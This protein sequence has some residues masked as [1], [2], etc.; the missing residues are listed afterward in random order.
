MMKQ[1]YGAALVLMA[2]AAGVAGEAAAQDSEIVGTA[3][4]PGVI[5]AFITAGAIDPNGKVPALNAVKGAGVTNISMASP[6][7]ILQ[8]G[9]SYAF[10]LA[11]QNIDFKGTCSDSYVLQRGAKIL[12]RGSIHTYACAPGTY[13]EWEIYSPAIPNSPGPATLVGTVTFKGQKA[14]TTANVII[15]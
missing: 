5:A 4:T 9:H 2:I 8:R 6:I 7:A 13:W 12:A 1:Y 3:A 14:T 15:R 10:L 11:S